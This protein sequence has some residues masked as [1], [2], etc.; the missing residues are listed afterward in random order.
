MDL[1]KIAFA[2]E[3]CVIIERSALHDW[4][5]KTSASGHDKSMNNLIRK[6]N[7]LPL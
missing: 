4:I 7:E 2:A 5:N 6:D 3:E 1:G